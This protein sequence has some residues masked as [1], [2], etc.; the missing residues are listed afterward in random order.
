MLERISESHHWACWAPGLTARVRQAWADW[1]RE[2]GLWLEVE[3]RKNLLAKLTEEAMRKRHEDN[4]HIPFRKGCPVCISAQGRQRSH[5][6][7][8]VGQV[9]A[10]SFDI[11]GPFVSGQCFD[12]VSSG[13]DRGRGYRYFLACAFTIP[14]SPKPPVAAADSGDKGDKD[15]PVDHGIPVEAGLPEESDSIDDWIDEL[16]RGEIAPELEVGFPGVEKAVRFRVR[17]KAPQERD[18]DSSTPEPPPP[19]PPPAEAPVKVVT[20]TLCLGVPLRSKK[21]KEV[22]GAVQQVINRLECFGFPVHRFH[23]DRAQELKSRTW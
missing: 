23:S 9:Y 5:W 7:A 2:R 15:L 16:F 22:M 10:A 17:S 3:E 19:L 11:A 18:D 6:R 20:R 12:P 8:A 21:G 1:G 13:R 4:D 14:L